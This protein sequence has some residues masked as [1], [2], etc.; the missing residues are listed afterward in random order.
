[1]I[2]SSS[3]L[4]AVNQY[5][6]E[7]DYF[8]KKQIL[9]LEIAYPAFFLAAFFPY[10]NYKRKS[11]MAIAV[12]WHACSSRACPSYLVMEKRSVPKLD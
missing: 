4:W 6:W 12:L 5:N 1:M 2:Y 11:F 3:M 7:S 8:Y 9:N 10:K